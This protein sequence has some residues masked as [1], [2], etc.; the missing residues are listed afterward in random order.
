MSLSNGN[1]IHSEPNKES[2]PEISILMAVYNGAPFIGAS[3]A[4]ALAQ[5]HPNFEVVVLDDG[6]SDETERICRTI[7]DPKFRYIR[8]ERRG[9]P[10]ALN[11]GIFAAKG[12]YIAVNDAD[13]LSLPHRLKY[14]LDFFKTHED[15]ALLAT[16]YTK[17][18]AFRQTISEETRSPLEEQNGSPV[19]IHPARLYRGNPFV[20]STLVFPKSVWKSAGKYDE[21]LSMC[22]DYDFAL[23]AAEFGRIAWLPGQ[24][25]QWYTNPTS[26]FKKKSTQ[27]YRNTLA[28]IKRR[29]RRLLN[30]PVW[31]RLYDM[32]PVYRRF[33]KRAKGIRARA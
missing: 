1:Q 8:K 2:D 3:I 30:L 19:W 13:D 32:V 18:A 24:T 10:N 7:N 9:F 22:V 16:A 6:S 31:I 33:L 27:E 4:A 28:F 26:F 25:V 11:E 23:R 29:A 5:D 17:V 15:V 14:V 20:H 21:K 12:K